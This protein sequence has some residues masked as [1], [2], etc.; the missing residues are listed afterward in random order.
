MAVDEA[1][2]SAFVGADSVEH[3]DLLTNCL[4]EAMAL[5]DKYVGEVPIPTPV[6]DRAYIEVGADLFHRRNAPHGISNQFDIHEGG[7]PLRIQRDPM[8]P[9]YPILRRWVTPW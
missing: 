7:N 1:R 9:A 8:A 5:V 6:R 3:A 2:L 4:A